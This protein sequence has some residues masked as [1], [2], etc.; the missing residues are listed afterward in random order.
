MVIQ[1]TSSS[2]VQTWGER[3]RGNQLLQSQNKLKRKDVMDFG[4]HWAYRNLQADESE[5]DQHEKFSEEES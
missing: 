1:T 3:K 2:R 5:E 4:E